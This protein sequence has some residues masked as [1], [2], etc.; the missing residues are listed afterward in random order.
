MFRL[1]NSR[2][3]CFPSL[4]WKKNGSRFVFC[5]YNYGEILQ[6][7]WKFEEDGC[8]GT[9]SP[10]MWF[11][12][13]TSHLARGHR[14]WGSPGPI[15]CRLSPVLSLSFWTVWWISSQAGNELWGD[16]LSYLSRQH[17][18]S[19][20]SSDLLMQLKRFLSLINPGLSHDFLITSTELSS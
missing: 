18:F 2:L 10:G 15:L 14:T 20:F 16:F 12:L 13:L 17:H 7:W 6:L 1:K 11:Q 19:C 5:S 8:W 3:W 9:T 4:N